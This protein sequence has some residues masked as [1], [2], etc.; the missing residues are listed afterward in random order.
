MSPSINVDR[1]TRL[2]QSVS[3]KLA[4]QQLPRLAGYL[5]GEGGEISY[6]L[7]GNLLT[8]ASGSQERRV[9]CIIYGW[10]LLFDPLTLAPSRHD[11]NI[12]SSLFL[13]ADESELPALELESEFEDYVVSGPD[14]DV[15]ERVE[16]EILLSLPS[17]TV[18]RDALNG[19][20]AE[21]PVPNGVKAQAAGMPKIVGVEGKKISPFAK[22]A[23]LKKK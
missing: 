14:M 23:E 8:D 22:L 11:F 10:F 4:P 21:Q 20:D 15:A 2:K 18:T 12:E 1:F 16:E 6:S 7:A 13:V 3:G 9:K 17:H 5:A 19:F